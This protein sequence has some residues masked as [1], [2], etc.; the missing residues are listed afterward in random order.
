MAVSLFIEDDRTTKIHQKHDN[1]TSNIAQSHI[2]GLLTYLKVK[3]KHFGIWA[4][5][6]VIATDVL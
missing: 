1:L 5:S 2:Q 6:R 4:S 3:R